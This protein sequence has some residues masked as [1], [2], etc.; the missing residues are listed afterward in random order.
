M[1]LPSE[2]RDRLTVEFVKRLEPGHKVILTAENNNP[3]HDLAVMVYVDDKFRGYIAREQCRDVRQL[4]NEDTPI[5]AVVTGRKEEKAF[6]VSIKGAEDRQIDLDLRRE[7]KLFRCP[8]GENGMVSFTQ[9]ENTFRMLSM[10]L[11][12]MDLTKESAAE[13][14]KS[15]EA[16]KNLLTMSVCNYDFYLLGVIIKRLGAF[17]DMSDEKA[18]AP[19]LRA[20]AEALQGQL[21]TCV[22]DMRP[23]NGL[24]KN[25]IIFLDRL[26]ADCGRTDALYKKYCQTYLDNKNFEEADKEK[27][28]SE[29]E[30]LQKWL[31]EIELFRPRDP[32]QLEE[33]ASQL[34]FRETTR[35]DI[36][37]I[38]SVLLLLDKFDE[39]LPDSLPA[40]PKDSKKTARGRQKK[41]PIKKKNDTPKTLMYFIHG[42][43]AVLKKQQKRVVYVYRLLNDWKWIDNE[44]TPDAFDDFFKGRP[45]HCNI[46]WR[47][48]STQLTILLQDLLKQQ[49]IEKQTGCAAKSL[50]EEQFGMT[51]NSDKRRLDD[52]S[53]RKIN[54]IVNILCINN[55]LSV[56]KVDGNEEEDAEIA[57]LMEIY[58]GEIRTTKQI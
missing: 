54:L 18:I 2:E 4:M 40:A 50:V 25:F 7:K 24:E 58:S 13:F 3:M 26:R 27:M 31:T 35:F 10:R 16:Y 57:V 32:G 30:E 34:A 51:P 21:S 55:P 5:E 42:N 43:K 49:Y 52:D 1:S 56:N 9:E 44:T 22:S 33:M 48:T 14:I 28:F 45:K 6:F 39:Y 12:S 20:Q 19:A 53:R 15:A 38:Y 11:A 36:Y 23:K 37:N 8:L 46:K 17:L 29:R 47:G 41:K